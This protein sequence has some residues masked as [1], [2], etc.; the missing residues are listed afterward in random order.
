[1]NLLDSITQKQVLVCIGTGG[2]G[3]TTISCS[4][5]IAIAQYKDAKVLVITIDPAKRLGSI[6]VEDNLGHK[7]VKIDHS[8]FIPGGKN[9]KGEVH[10]VTI[11]MSQG[12]DELVERFMES[13]EGS[14]KIFNNVM[15]QNLTTRFT[16][17]HDFIAMDQLFEY[18]YKGEY[19]YIVLD[20]PPM[21]QAYGFFDAPKI[22]SEFFGGKIIN[23]VT[24]PYRLSQSS[25]SSKIFD[26]ATQPFFTLAN[27]VLGK[28]FLN[29]IGEFFFLFKKIY[30]PLIKRSKDITKF[31][32]SDSLSCA[33]II[34]PAQLLENNIETTIEE[35]KDRSMTLNNVVLN[36][37]PYSPADYKE[38]ND[39][40]KENE[41]KLDTAFKDYLISEIDVYK[42]MAIKLNPQNKGF[43][44]SEF[45]L[46]D[47]AMDIYVLSKSYEIDLSKRLTKLVELVLESKST[48]VVDI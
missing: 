1:M 30:D 24:S 37:A 41:D 45:N 35:L 13:K 28:N 27:K 23:L 8:H 31:L 19:D 33:L 25:K 39:F 29:D 36:M 22:V 46:S 18:Y 44:N 40:I 5:A 2:V 47:E 3:K 7:P 34:N 10:A 12:W 21:S 20:T 14:K 6:L 11:N 9:L 42:K 15:Y 32:Q 43:H 26:I 17:S 48:N 38:V 4:L 16:H